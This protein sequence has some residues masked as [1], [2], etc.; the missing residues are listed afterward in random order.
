[1]RRRKGMASSLR[2]KPEPDIEHG[3]ETLNL[4][5]ITEKLMDSEEG[6]GWSRQYCELV[7]VEYRRFLA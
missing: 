3:L 2:T 4:A 7:A 6:Q 1:L 5:M